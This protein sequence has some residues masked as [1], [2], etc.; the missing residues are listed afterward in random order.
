MMP[1][2]G[3]TELEIKYWSRVWTTASTVHVLKRN[4][5]AN[6]CCYGDKP[7]VPGLK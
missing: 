7:G 4:G 5:V 3:M 6:D 2:N 1:S